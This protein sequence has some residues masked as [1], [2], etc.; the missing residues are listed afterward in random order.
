MQRSVS[1][2]TS[3]CLNI[4]FTIF[5]S[6]TSFWE[7]D[8]GN[9]EG[10]KGLR[11]YTSFSF[12][13]SFCIYRER[14]HHHHLPFMGNLYATWCEQPDY[15]SA[16]LDRQVFTAAHKT[17]VSLSWVNDRVGG[18]CQPGA[19]TRARSTLQFTPSGQGGGG[20]GGGGVGGGRRKDEADDR[21]NEAVNQTSA[22]TK[23]D[24]QGNAAGQT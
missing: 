3:T 18:P 22:K 6:L 8:D 23:K 14:Q 21:R 15:P 5:Y 24:R 10:T 16:G 1:Y 19:W 7:G 11:T 13:A 20:V 17:R 12:S 9:L 2:A 4:I